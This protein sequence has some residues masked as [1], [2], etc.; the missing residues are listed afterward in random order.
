MLL[1]DTNISVS[2]FCLNVVLACSIQIRVGLL[3]HI[4]L[5]VKSLKMIVFGHDVLVF[6]QNSIK[7]DTPTQ[8]EEENILGW[9][10]IT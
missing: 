5:E 10:E 8:R 4:Y 6:L 1:T 9:G 7:P 2:E 3:Q